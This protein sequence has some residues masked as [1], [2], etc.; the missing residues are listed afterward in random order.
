MEYIIK[1]YRHEDFFH[2]FE[3]ISQIPRGSGNEGGMVEYLK[4]F[5]EKHGLYFY[6]DEYRNV[7]M[8]KEASAGY[9][10]TAPILLQGHTDM[11]CEKNGDSTHDFEKDPLD[12]YID[13]GLLRARGTT[14]GGDDGVAVAA[15][16]SVLADPS[17]EHPMLECLF[18]SG[19]ETGLYGAHGFD[20][21]LIQSRRILNLDTELDGEAIASC[22]GSADLIFCRECELEKTKEHTLNITVKG[23]AGGHSG[24]DIHT[25]R[26]NAI[27]ILG[28]ILA[29][30]YDDCP[31]RLA[32][33]GGGNKRNAIPR[34]AY[35]KLIVLDLEKAKALAQDESRRI[36]AELVEADKKFF[37]QLRRGPLV[38]SCFSYKDTSAIINMTV[39]PVNG[40]VSKSPAN[41]AFV[42]T[43]A[44]MGVI[45]AAD[46]KVEATVMARSSC[47][48]EMDA[49]LLSYKRLAKACAWEMILEE[50]A[51]GWDLDPN[52][53][54]A[55]DYLRIYKTLFPE[56]DPV[57]NAIHAG[58]E[59]GIFVGKIEGLDA[60]SVGPTIYEIHSPDEAL[61]LASCE[62]FCDLVRAMVSEK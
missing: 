24:A 40:V 4:A 8:R 58:L 38:D 10:A 16:L 31:F 48:S 7:F 37:V 20:C 13:N 34:E 39:L 18:T 41:P 5:A 35:A 22:A 61:D 50:R 3:E 27:R 29:R 6:T 32:D 1:G 44:N 14:L 21:S 46:G 26:S 9:E 56:S 30:L 36:A 55:S 51:C 33:I 28:R 11:V 59:C 25:G 47:D 23:L 60:L 45:T 17:L 57:V 19:E 49:L 62:R 42:R 43:S 52:S 15:M 54:L 2:Y 53:R 12:L